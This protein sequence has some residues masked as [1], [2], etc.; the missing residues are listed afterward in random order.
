MIDKENNLNPITARSILE[1]KYGQVWD[2]DQLNHD[3]ETLAF[4]PPVFIVRHKSHNKKG[5][6]LFQDKPRFY[7]GFVEKA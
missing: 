1:A 6:I 3:F 4:L 5:S 2:N 7:Y